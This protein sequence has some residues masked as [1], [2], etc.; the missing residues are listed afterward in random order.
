MQ[1]GQPAFNTNDLGVTGTPH[2]AE[3]EHYYK[4][5]IMENITTLTNSEGETYYKGECPFTGQD[6][7]SFSEDFEDFWTQEDEDLYSV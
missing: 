7:Y 3:A 2:G 4:N 1:A 5:I 6:I